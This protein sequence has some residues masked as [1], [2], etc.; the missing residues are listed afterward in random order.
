[1]NGV[2]I[3]GGSSYL[4]RHLVRLLPKDNDY[5]YT[6]FSHDPLKLPNG[7]FL[8]LLDQNA[9]F[10][11]VHTLRPKTIIHLAGSNRSPQMESLIHNGTAHL[12]KA[13]KAINARLIHLSTDSIFDGFHPPYM[14]SAV[15]SPVNAYGRAKTAAEQIVK[16]ISN[17]VIIRTSLIYGIDEMDH[18]T[19]WMAKSI[20]AG[21][22]ITL[23]DNQIR[24]PI[25]VDSLSQACLELI[26]HP[27]TGTLNV[28][29]NQILTRAEFGLKMLKYW[30]IDTRSL[31][32]I[33]SSSGK[34]PLNCELDITLATAV[35]H[36]PLPGVDE[37]IG[38]QSNKLA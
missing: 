15:P 38:F 17:H 2:L 4:G 34:W 1:M 5:H 12:V 29:G 35:L 31:V 24:N 21:S 30:Q 32:K 16:E 8:N 10:D 23:F 36:T 6:Y 27:F 13:A 26:D 7:R 33:S 14:E 18:G 22:P 9:L 37:V 3:T 19:A 25:W 20:R 28:A 11:C